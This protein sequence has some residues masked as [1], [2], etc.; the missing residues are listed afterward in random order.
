MATRME[1][2]TTNSMNYLEPDGEDESLHAQQLVSGV[3]KLD[4]YR[5]VR[6]L[7]RIKFD[8]SQALEMT[9]FSTPYEK[10]MAERLHRNTNGWIDTAKDVLCVAIDV[11]GLG[12]IKLIVKEDT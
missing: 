9:Q 6:E 3:L 8:S 11:N 12:N 4:N 10:T 5:P 7:E 2:P 1:V